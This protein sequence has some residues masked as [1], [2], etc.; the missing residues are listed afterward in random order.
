MLLF[1]LRVANYKGRRGGGWEWG[2]GNPQWRN[3]FKSFCKITKL[4]Q[5]LKCKLS[6]RTLSRQAYFLCP[7]LRKRLDYVLYVVQFEVRSQNFAKSDC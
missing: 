7:I 1:L 5:E 4:V 2:G 6:D 3:I